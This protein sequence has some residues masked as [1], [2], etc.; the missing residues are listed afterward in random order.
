MIRTD[1]GSYNQSISELLSLNEKA[2][3]FRFELTDEAV[4]IYLDG[5]MMKTVGLTAFV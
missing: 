4:E 3:N 2:V 5:Q 1:E